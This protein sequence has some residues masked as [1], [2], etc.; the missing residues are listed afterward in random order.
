MSAIADSG[1]YLEQ[2]GQLANE[3]SSTLVVPANLSDIASMIAMATGVVK[4]QSGGT[5][6]ARQSEWVDALQCRAP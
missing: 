1:Q 5:T 6:P 2:F 3:A 4:H